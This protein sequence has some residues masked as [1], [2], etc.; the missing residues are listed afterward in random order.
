MRRALY[1]SCQALRGVALLLLPFIPEA[2]T[3]LLDR[4]GAGAEL[5]TARLP[6][7]AHAWDV[8]RPGTTTRK[9]SALF[10]RAEL[11]T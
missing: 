10:P 2:A 4:L 1:T 8:L 7:A 3:E 6:D 9:G 11:P 5:E